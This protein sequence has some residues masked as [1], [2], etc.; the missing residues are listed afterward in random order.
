MRPPVSRWPLVHPRP[1]RP[2]AGAGAQPPARSVR[3]ARRR[4]WAAQA[5]ASLRRCGQRERR[6]WPRRSSGLAAAGRAD[7]AEQKQ[8]PRRAP[9]DAH[10]Q[11]QHPLAADVL[12]GAAADPFRQSPSDPSRKEQ[13]HSN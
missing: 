12:H 3:R 1:A 8:W 7:L 9:R 10:Q 11:Q 5:A 4:H 2:R 13:K 6:T